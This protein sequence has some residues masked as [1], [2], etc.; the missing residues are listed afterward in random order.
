MRLGRGWRELDGRLMML[1]RG[2]LLLLLGVVIP[3]WALAGK[4]GAA[5]SGRLLL[6]FA[7]R[8][9][10]SMRCGWWRW[11]DSEEEEQR[12]GNRSDVGR[13]RGV[14]RGGNSF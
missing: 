6:A 13:G 11:S 2:L 3:P 12:A 9:A 8:L 10:W 7:S 4:A 5:T 1:L 14:G